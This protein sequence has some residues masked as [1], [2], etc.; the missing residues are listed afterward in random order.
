MKFG[1]SMSRMVLSAFLV[2]NVFAPRVADAVLE[3]YK[4]QLGKFDQKMTDTVKRIGKKFLE[5][6]ECVPV[7]DN[8]DPDEYA[9]LN[10]G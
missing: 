10:D 5:A 4:E 6:A 9:D 1:A 3:E 8:S 7:A 2:K